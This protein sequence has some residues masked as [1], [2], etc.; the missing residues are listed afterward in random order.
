MEA[1]PRPTTE[2]LPDLPVEEPAHSAS[3]AAKANAAAPAA[4][5][6]PPGPSPAAKT[7]GSA[8]AAP[9]IAGTQTLELVDPELL[10][11]ASD[12]PT[13][14]APQNAAEAPQVLEVD[15]HAPLTLEDPAAVEKLL[16]APPAPAA[17]RNPP[18]VS[19]APA[20]SS[21]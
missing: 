17:P 14:A 16:A 20:P 7:D 1:A 15:P 3:T 4:S 5:E 10:L 9:D 13:V 18:V 6:K 19:A 11:S 12:V 21:D 8:P 2:P